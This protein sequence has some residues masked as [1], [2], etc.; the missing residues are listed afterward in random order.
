MSKIYINTDGGARGNPGP[1]AVGVVFYDES[2]NVIHKF[3][4]YIGT[5]TNNVAEYKALIYALEM[6]KKSRWL[7][8]AKN[9]EI[10]CRLDSQLVVEQVK[11]SYKVKNLDLK[12]LYQK[13]LIIITSLK[14]K[15]YFCHVSR[16][17][18]VLADKLVNSALDKE[19]KSK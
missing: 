17:E 8:E 9:P 10:Y 15:I 16:E 13:L 3:S 19:L 14:A 7:S 2:E 12:D 18:N 11:G 4:K 6:L 5:A 1:A